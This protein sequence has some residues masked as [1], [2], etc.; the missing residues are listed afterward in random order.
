MKPVLGTSFW[1]S[2]RSSRQG[3]NA[4]D[5]LLD[6]VTGV[7]GDG[8]LFECLRLSSEWFL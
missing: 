1:M 5:I 3:R 2:T 4:K 6:V 7:E 8:G